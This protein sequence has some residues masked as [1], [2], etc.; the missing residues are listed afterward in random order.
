MAAAITTAFIS[1]P[2]TLSLCQSQES[3]AAGEIHAQVHDGAPPCFTEF[4]K[5]ALEN[6]KCGDAKL[7]MKKQKPPPGLHIIDQHTTREGNYQ[8]HT[9]LYDSTPLPLLFPAFWC[10]LSM[11]SSTQTH[12]MQCGSHMPGLRRSMQQTLL[13]GKVKTLPKVPSSAH[14]TLPECK[15]GPKLPLLL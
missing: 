1:Y 8:W 5:R 12:R 3:W 13:H 7:A 11:S 9:Y 4:K 2:K 10:C 6:Q 14:T 15:S